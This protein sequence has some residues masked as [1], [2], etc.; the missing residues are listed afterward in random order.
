MLSSPMRNATGLALILCA[1]LVQAATPAGANYPGKPV[2]ILVGFT[3]GGS[4]DIVA[5]LLA[6]RLGAAW[7][8][9]VVVDN[10][11][12]AGANIAAEV[13]ARSPADGYTLLL[14]QNSL[15]IS[16]AL[17]AKLNYD[18][19]KDLVALAAVASSPHLLVVHPSL[20]V[21][22]VGALIALAR[23]RPGELNFASS[24]VGI[25]DH[26]GGELFRQMA[27]LD[28]VHVPYKGGAEST[29]S[30]LS[31]ETSFYFAGILTV[32]PLIKQ[33][34]LRPLAVTSTQRFKGAMEL[35]TMEETGLKG[36]ELVLWQGLFGPTGIDPSIVDRIA[37]DVSGLLRDPATVSQFDGLGLT[38]FSRGPAEFQAFFELETE[39]WSRVLRG[40]GSKP[41]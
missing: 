36:F 25:N 9:P 22:N 28:V 32:L 41:K 23:A 40:D 15:A 16:P 17:Y 8:Q 21:R 20:P 33:E 3:P 14:A 2:R 35:P 6:Q 12:G 34:R 31:G 24:G 27:K 38:P 39:K 19:R 13:A 1:A 5:R 10:R 11:P 29:R 4:T 37:K 30:I 26:M 18:A 7:G